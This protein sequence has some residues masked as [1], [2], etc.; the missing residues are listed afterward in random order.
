MHY[1]GINKGK[2]VGIRFTSQE[3]F[4][5]DWR[6]FDLLTQQLPGQFINPIGDLE[7]LS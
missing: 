5:S 7:C 2:Y 4:S 1:F 3:I 6:R